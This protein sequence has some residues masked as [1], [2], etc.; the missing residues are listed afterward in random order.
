MSILTVAFSNASGY[1]VLVSAA[2]IIAELPNLTQDERG[3][4][5]RRLRELEEAD[6]TQFLHEAAL[7][8]FQEVDRM[9]H[10]E[11]RAMKS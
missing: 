7:Q 3:A 9:D 2:E 6:A 8:T 4:I 10:P 11:T 1:C 5:T